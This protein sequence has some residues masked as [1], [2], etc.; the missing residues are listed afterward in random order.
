MIKFTSAKFQK[1]FHSIYIILRIQKLQ[2]KQWRVWLGVYYEPRWTIHCNESLHLNNKMKN[3]YVCDAYTLWIVQYF[4]FCPSSK[5]TLLK[6]WVLQGLVLLIL[7]HSERPKLYA[8]LAFLSAIRLTLKEL[9]KQTAKFTTQNF[10]TRNV[11]KVCPHLLPL[12]A[13]LI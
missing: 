9:K 1:M 10:K 6:I 13:T 12:W 3:R 4:H 5:I 7:L 11:S 8:I 2:G